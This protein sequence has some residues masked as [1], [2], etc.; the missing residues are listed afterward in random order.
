[1]IVNSEVCHNIGIKCQVKDSLVDGPAGQ[2][3][4]RGSDIPTHPHTDVWGHTQLNVLKLFRDGVQSPGSEG[5]GE[6]G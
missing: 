2:V 4:G 1:M 5:I 6:V 3:V